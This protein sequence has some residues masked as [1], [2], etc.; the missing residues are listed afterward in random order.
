MREFFASPAWD[1]GIR[2]ETVEDQVF[3]NGKNAGNGFNSRN[4]PSDIVSRRHLLLKDPTVFSTTYLSTNVFDNDAISR[5]RHNETVQRRGS[6]R[7]FGQ[8]IV[9]FLSR[10]TLYVLANGTKHR[11][12]KVSCGP[13]S[14]HLLE[15]S[16]KVEL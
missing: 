16:N 12:L 2:T 7:Q 14:I 10:R 15:E 5:V 6:Y 1:H 4:R 9:L 13:C 3:F 8:S 11:A